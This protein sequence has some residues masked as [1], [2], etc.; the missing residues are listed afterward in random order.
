MSRLLRSRAWSVLALLAGITSVWAGDVLWLRLACATALVIGI[1][2]QLALLALSIRMR[3]LGTFW[4]RLSTAAVLGAGVACW[5]LAN[6]P[7]L[8]LLV[9]A[10]LLLVFAGLWWLCTALKDVDVVQL[11]ARN[12]PGAPEEPVDPPR[13][14]YGWAGAVVCGFLVLGFVAATLTLPAAVFAVLA[15]LAVAMLAVIRVQLARFT[16]Y[17]QQVLNKLR[18]YR[19]VLTMPYNGHAGFHI[20]LWSPYLERTGQ[21][22]TVV[23][24]D[25]LAFQRVAERYTI[26]VIYAKRGDLRAIRAMLP[27]TVRAALYVY[28]RDN[29]DFRKVRRRVTH[30]WLHHGDSDKEACFRRKSAAYDVL[31][32]AGQAAIDRYTT[33]GVRIPSEKFKILGR[34]QIENIQTAT[35]SISTV[36][37]PIVLYAPTWYAVDYKNN[38]SSLPIGTAIV[39]ALLARKSTVIF[40][41]HP[42][43]RT[44]PEAAAAI[45]AIHELL[46]ADA[47][48]TSRPHRW[49]E[50][51]DAPFAELANVADAMVADVSGVVTDFMQSLKPFAMVATGDTTDTFRARFP[52]SRSAYVIEWDLSTLDDA[53]DAMVGDDP[54]AATRVTRREYYLGGYENGESARAFVSYLKSLTADPTLMEAVRVKPAV[55]AQTVKKRLQPARQ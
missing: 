44:L 34:P 20:G 10:G 11:Q 36:D 27:K 25:P 38:H 32:V 2:Q 48:A 5:Y 4:V 13:W 18:A 41:P 49:G 46:R 40:R 54:L 43:N 42:A 9:V 30:V 8:P 22:F 37:N 31:V 17:N 1:A 14:P 15:V 51:A 45:A 12:L 6:S 47:E 16:R 19:P 23:T 35:A 26:P 7:R 53:L 24:T 55:R 3:M 33:H 50:A 28:S 29:D 39:S 21:P 52:S